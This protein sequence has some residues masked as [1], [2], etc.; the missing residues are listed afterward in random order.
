MWRTSTALS[1][2]VGASCTRRG[3]GFCWVPEPTFGSAPIIVVTCV[4]CHARMNV[5][6]CH[7]IRDSSI[8][9]YVT[10]EYNTHP[11]Y[12]RKLN[13]AWCRVSLSTRVHTWLWYCV[14][15]CSHM[16]SLS[17]TDACAKVEHT[18]NKTLRNQPSNYVRHE[19]L[20]YLCCQ[21]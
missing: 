13:M 21:H 7:G 6:N 10:Y 19:L 1:P 17:Y 16:W 11:R 8:N 14:H 2:V 12:W 18:T 20:W 9:K 3:T 5:H 4:A 15:L